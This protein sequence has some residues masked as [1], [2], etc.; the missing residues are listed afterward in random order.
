MKNIVIIGGGTGTFTLLSGLRKFPTNNSVIVSSADDG[1]STGRLRK[2]L[3]VF[4]PGDLRQCLLGLSYTEKETQDLFAYRFEKGELQGHTVGNIIIAALSKTLGGVESAIKQA[5]KM[6]NVRGEVVPV[7]LFPTKL[8]ATLNNGK[9]VVGEHNIDEPKIKSRPA[10]KSLQ[11]S[12]SAPANKR[13]LRSLERADVIVLGP[14]DLF[15]SILP[16]LLVKGVSEAIAK[17]KAKKVLVVNLMTKKGQTDNFTAAD[18]VNTVNKYLGKAKLDTVIINNKKPA[19]N[20]LAK[21]KKEGAKLIAAEGVK[22]LKIKAIAKD[23]LSKNV[24]GKVN[25]DSLKRSYLR[26]D[27]DKLAKIIY[28]L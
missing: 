23:L 2:E 21:Y 25:G 16:N 15:T 10:I 7:T 5:S 11:L 12:P 22:K 26:H 8:S 24:F 20:I 1:G 28:E 4:P 9:T 27:P 14:G 19:V 13:V 17:S 3:D 18:F 6:L